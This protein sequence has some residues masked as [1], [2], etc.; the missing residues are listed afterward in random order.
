[1]NEKGEMKLSCVN[2]VV[3]HD[4][5]IKKDGTVVIPSIFMFKGGAGEC[6]P[7]LKMCRDNNCVVHFKNEN[8]TIYPDRQDDSVSLKLLIHLAI[9]GSHEFGDDFIRYLNNMEKMSWEA[10]SVQ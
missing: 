10:V 4:E 1:M 9:A 2:R 7:F 5:V 3:P 8:L 6:Y